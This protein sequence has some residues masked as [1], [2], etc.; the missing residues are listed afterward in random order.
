VFSN[1][2]PDHPFVKIL[3]RVATTIETL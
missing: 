3:E 1:E 2:N